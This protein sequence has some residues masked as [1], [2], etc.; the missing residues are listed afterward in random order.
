MFLTFCFIFFIQVYSS[1]SPNPN[2]IFKIFALGVF[3]A[4]SSPSC[5]SSKVQRV[6]NQTAG[7]RN[8]P[9]VFGANSSTVSKV[10]IVPHQIKWPVTEMAHAFSIQIAAHSA[11][12]HQKGQRLPYQARGQLFRCCVSY[13]SIYQS[14]VH[15]TSIM[16][17]CLALGPPRLSCLA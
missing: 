4:N 12:H 6:L 14:I 5:V 10:Q 17:A 11:S 8:C 15:A 2:E 16:Q 3:C 1:R 13:G 7:H 9:R